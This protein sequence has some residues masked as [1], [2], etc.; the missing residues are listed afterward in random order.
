[1][2]LPLQI[3][4]PHQKVQV[5]VLTTP[6]PGSSPQRKMKETQ[7][8]WMEPHY[9]R[10]LYL[11]IHLLTKNDLYPPNQ[12]LWFLHG[13]A[14][15]GEEWEFLMCTFPVV[16]DGNLV[17]LLILLRGPFCSLFSA[18]FLKTFLSFLLVILLCKMT[19]S[20]VWRLVFPC[21]RS[22]DVPSGENPCVR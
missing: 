7:L 8:E 14:Q 11:R 6:N 12:H 19:R 10:I 1:V 16:G 15:W 17:S 22:G 9:L 20:V 13:H 21:T 5:V 3:T 18:T 2:Q 4:S